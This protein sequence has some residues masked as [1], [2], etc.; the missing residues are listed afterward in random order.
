MLMNV[1]KMK[2]Y[3]FIY[4]IILCF[5]VSVAAQAPLGITDTVNH[6]FKPFPE[7]YAWI[8]KGDTAKATIAP[9]K[10]TASARNKR[11]K[12][13]RQ[14]R[15]GMFI[16]WGVYAQT[17]GYYKGNRIQNSR[18]MNTSEWIFRHAKISIDEFEKSIAA[19]EPKDFNATQWVQLAKQAGMKYL[20]I[21]AKHHDGFAIWPSN[22]GG[23]NIQQS[24]WWKQ[25]HRDPL[26]ELAAACKKA[27]VVFGV[28]YSVLDWSHP[29]YDPQLPWLVDQLNQRPNKETYKTYMKKQLK[30]LVDNYHPQL[31]W[32]D[33]E[34]DATW[35]NDDGMEIYNYLRNVSPSSI[36]NN[37]LGKNTDNQEIHVGDYMSA[38]QTIP[39]NGLPGLDWETCL[40]MNNTWGY[41][42]DD[43]KWKST[44]TI[45]H[46]LSEVLQKGGNFLLNVGP[47]GTGKIPAPSVDT[48]KKAGV[49]VNE[50]KEK[51]IIKN[52]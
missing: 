35:T 1:N 43:N 22:A 32:F 24:N 40:T 30:E 46:K 47:D 50:H 42:R 33:G 31:F 45:T 36:I 38:E 16:H 5:P 51:F 8:M 52:R 9:V 34:W 10:E 19:F 41:D 2:N 13:F 28:Y 21:T 20:V 6:I 29:S 12:W 39:E 49:W 7:D 15:F 18:G 11:V 4:L 25:Q 48:L 17:A 27:G 44:E 14:S 3:N 23:F 26:K 37:R